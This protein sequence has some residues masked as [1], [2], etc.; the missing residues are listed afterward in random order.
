M[1]LM[2]LKLYN[3]RKHIANEYTKHIPSA[4]NKF[5]IKY[6]LFKIIDDADK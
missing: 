1:R 5:A 6:I 2:T 4:Q 3:N